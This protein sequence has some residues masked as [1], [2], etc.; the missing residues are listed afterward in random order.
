V[1]DYAI[2]NFAGF[3][4]LV[5]QID[6]VPVYFPNPARDLASFFDMPTA[7]CHVLNG[8]EALNYVRSRHYEEKID[9]SWRQ[10][11]RNDYGRTERQRDFLILAL[12]RLTSRG[13]RN[14]S[15]MR[16][17]LNTAIDNHAMTLDDKLTAKDLLDIGRAFG[18]FRPEYLQRFL[19]PVSGYVT[20]GGAA[21]VGLVD[22]EAAPILDVFRGLGNTTQPDQITVRVADNRGRV[23]EATTPAHLLTDAGFR[24]STAARTQTAPGRTTVQFTS[25][26]RN[27]A[28]VLG[29][30]LAVT[31]V[32]QHII[33]DRNLTL[34][35]STDFQ[36]L[37]PAPADEAQIAPLVDQSLAGALASATSP[38][39]TS[40]TNPATPDVPPVTTASTG[41]IGLTPEGVACS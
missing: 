37:R 31:P 22:D 8:E 33:G 7:G 17:L 9:G 4:K 20:N 36:G 19:L 23:T 10:D 24:V 39:T 35:V 28:I 21:V 6:G 12:E 5:D 11:N 13:G 38:G 26:Q 3:R 14:P 29:R 41:I 30:H 15:T 40:V 1:N 34:I 16:R 32:F 27:A 2:V 25:D 18:D